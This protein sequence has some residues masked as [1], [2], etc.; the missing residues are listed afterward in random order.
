ML[1]KAEQEYVAYYE[2]HR[3]SADCNKLKTPIESKNVLAYLTELA[4]L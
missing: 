2:G 3:R 4:N 1:R